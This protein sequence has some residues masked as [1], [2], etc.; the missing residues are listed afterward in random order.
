MTVVLPA[1]FG[2]I[3]AWRAHRLDLQR[4]VAGDLKAAELLFESPGFQRERHG[5]SLRRTVDDGL[6]AAKQPDDQ[7]R[8]P[9]RPA[10]QALASD[11]HDHHQHEAD[12]ELP[13]LRRE[14]GKEFLQHPEHDGA[15]QPAIEIAGAADHQHQHQVGRALEREHVERRQRRGLGEQRAGYSGVERRQRVDRD[16]APVDGNADRGRAQRVVADRPQRQAERRVH[17][18]SCQQEQQKQH[19]KAVEEADLAEHVEGEQA[20]DRL[21]RDALQPVGAAGDV[22]KAFRQRLQQQRD[23]ERHHQPG[24]IDAPD[25]QEAREKAD[26]RG[27]KPGRHQRHHRLVDDAVQREQSGAIGADAEERGMAERYDTGIAQDQV[28]RQREQREPHDFRHDEIAGGKQQARRP[29]RESRT[30]SRSS[31]SA[32]AAGIISDVGWRGHVGA[33]REATRPNRPFGRQIRMTIMMV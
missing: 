19:N 24:Q 6:A 23:P 26:H 20:Q 30:R 33:Q 1:P 2:P 8:R 18:P 21:H 13:I 16:Q 31:A 7:V 3:S 17:D 25:D 29:A 28:E 22:G 15:D 11:Q 5:A 12:P 27:G 32:R 10:V 4:K 9:Q 14:I